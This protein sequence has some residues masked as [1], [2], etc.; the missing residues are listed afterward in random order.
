MQVI[1]LD[2]CALIAFLAR[3]N[4]FEVVFKLLKQSRNKELKLCMSA[5]NFGEV[6]TYLHKNLPSDA[7]RVIS[8][9]YKLT[10]EIIKADAELAEVAGYYK[11]LGGVAYPDCFVLSL[12]KKLQAKIVTKDSE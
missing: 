9:L 8:R 2:S 10:V 11:S 4:N 3:E 5:V 1:V 12:A 6:C 7:N